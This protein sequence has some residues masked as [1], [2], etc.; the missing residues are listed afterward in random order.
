MTFATPV[1][2]QVLKIRV[3]LLVMVAASR[4]PNGPV[5][6]ARRRLPIAC[7]VERLRLVRQGCRPTTLA[8]I[9]H[10][11]DPFR[12]LVACVIS[13]RT[14]DAVTETASRRL[15][16]RA[17][18]PKALAALSQQQ[19]DKLIYPAGFHAVKARQLRAIAHLL[20]DRYDSKVPPDRDALLGL[21]GVGHKT[22]NLVLGLGF[23]IPAICVDTHVHRISNRLGLVA[24]KT[25]EQTEKALETILPQGVW[26]EINDLMVTFG[27]NVCQPTSPQ[28][29]QCPVKRCPR[30]GVTRSR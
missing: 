15:F 28:C 10:A 29:S 5:K 1:T 22:A 17:A 24:T 26:I 4:S 3:G 21:P 12:L 16:A 13:L 25:P 14:K 20:V 8:E 6:A 2:F 27:Q 23:A 30:V 11:R 18:T 9:E 7:L 19:I